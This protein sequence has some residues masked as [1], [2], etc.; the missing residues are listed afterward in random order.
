[1]RYNKGATVYKMNIAKKRVLMCELLVAEIPTSCVRHQKTN[2]GRKKLSFDSD[3]KQRLIS[4]VA[5]FQEAVFIPLCSKAAAWIPLIR[6]PHI[7]S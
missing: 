2:Y 7:P 1:M 4:L 5:P 6:T 3:N